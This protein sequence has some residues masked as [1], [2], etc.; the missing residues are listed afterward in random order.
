[1]NREM[2]LPL[3]TRPHVVLAAGLLSILPTAALAEVP[4]PV[5]ALID[6]A[7]ATGDAGKVKT[8]IALAKTTNP[9]DAAELDAILQGFEADQSAK[10]ELAAKAKEEAIR[11]A[12]LFENW[13]G[14]GELGAFRS[15][16]NAD[17]TGL[18]AAISLTR[19]GIDWQHKLIARADYQ[20]S[21]GVTTR[22]QYFASYEPNVRLDDDFYAYALAQYEGDRFQGFSARYAL[23]GGI[24][25]KVIDSED[26]Q[27]SA[28]IGPAYRVTRFLDDRSESRIAGLLGIDFDWA[29]TDRLKLTHDTNAVAETGGSAVVIVD[30]RNTSL[31]LATGLNAKISNRMSARV[32]YT[33]EYDSNPPPGAVQTDTLSRVTLIY[34]F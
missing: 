19:T 1:M 22:E 9:D 6:A 27:L 20:E 33:V 3:S 26:L 17:N 8:V 31:N 10:A 2:Q 32:S 29:I 21:N 12:G 11:N 28:K 23:S 4:P 30:S 24:G 16:G 34:D 13:N 15:T 7:I 25:Y 18:T 5:R 14:R